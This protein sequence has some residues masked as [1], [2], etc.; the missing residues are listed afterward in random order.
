MASLF[1]QRNDGA[2]KHPGDDEQLA[3]LLLD[4]ALYS[5][6]LYQ[7]ACDVQSC[8]LPHLTEQMPVCDWSLKPLSDGTSRECVSFLHKCAQ[9]W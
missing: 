6:I 3:A 1:R 8:F 2:V 5:V 9:S 7:H 4:V